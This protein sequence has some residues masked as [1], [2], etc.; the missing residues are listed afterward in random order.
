MYLLKLDIHKAQANTGENHA[1]VGRGWRGAHEQ[2]QENSVLA[3]VKFHRWWGI[4]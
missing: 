4:D 3:L 1:G 2:T